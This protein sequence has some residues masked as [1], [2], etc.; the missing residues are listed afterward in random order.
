MAQEETEFPEFI[1]EMLAEDEKYETCLS[2]NVCQDD[3]SVELCLETGVST[4]L[5]R[6]KGEGADIG[7][8]RCL[9]T[10]RV[11]GCVL[12]LMKNNLVVHHDGPL[13][14]NEGF[15]KDESLP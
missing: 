7:L 10:K 11:I 4:S 8:L 3:S 13:R 9:D 2:L 14:I 12:P 5:E 15:L 1:K 6:I